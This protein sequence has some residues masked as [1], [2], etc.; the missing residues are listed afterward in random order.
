[1]LYFLL[2]AALVV[3]DQLV[4][5]L[6]RA[7]IPLGEGVPFIPHILQLTY[8]QNTGA[9]FSIFEQHTWVLTL[10]SAVASVLLIVLLAK[11]TF[12]HPFAMVSLALVLAGAVGN[13]IDRLFLGYV[14]DMFQTLFMN[15]PIFNVADICIVCGGIAFCVYFLL[16]C[17][18]EDKA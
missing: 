8:Y 3:V 6:V 13:L 11:R 4:K 15:F 14:T 7:N 5:F 12:N 10:I 18:E 17:K 2:A 1:M 16:F 9:A